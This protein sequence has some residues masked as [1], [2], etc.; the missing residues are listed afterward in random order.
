MRKLLIAAI[1]L[2]LSGAATL[3]DPPSAFLLP[4]DEE[5]QLARPGLLQDND[6]VQPDRESPVVL[7][8]PLA[9]SAPVAA[10]VRTV[11]RADTDDAKR[12]RI[13]RMPWQTGVFQ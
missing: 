11:A 13:T 1:L 7:T 8:A 3:A 5:L 10:P 9:L 2:P 4:S 12:K 6:R